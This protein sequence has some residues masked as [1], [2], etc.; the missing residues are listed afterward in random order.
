MASPPSGPANETLRGVLDTHRALREGFT[1]LDDAAAM[2]AMLPR[3]TLRENFPGTV[4]ATPSDPWSGAPLD[5]AHFSESPAPETGPTSRDLAPN[6]SNARSGSERGV[7]ESP[8][9][10]LEPTGADRFRS[11]APIEGDEQKQTHSPVGRVSSARR[12]GQM[13]TVPVGHELHALDVIAV[14][15][16]FPIGVERGRPIVDG[17]LGLSAEPP[18][19]SP[20]TSPPPGGDHTAAPEPE[21]KPGPGAATVKPSFLLPGS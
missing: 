15:P 12:P 8:G 9:S 7:P 13:G 14:P 5:K 21:A 19:T 6:A 11:G 20:G 3:K 16:S 4:P 18:R 10:E 17:P 2:R 1:T